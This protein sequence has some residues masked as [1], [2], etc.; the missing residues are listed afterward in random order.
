MR[1]PVDTP[2]LDAQ[3]AAFGRGLDSGDDRGFGRRAAAEIGA[4]H[5]HAS[6]E[7]KCGVAHQQR[8]HQLLLD[9]P[10]RRLGHSEPAGEFDRGDALLRLGHVIDRQE[11]QAERQLGRVKQ[12]AGDRRHLVAAGGTLIQPPAGDLA[13]APGATA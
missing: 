10:G 5:L 9:L 13:M 4:I 8:L 12:R 6:G 2:E 11:P 3:G 7:R 1:L